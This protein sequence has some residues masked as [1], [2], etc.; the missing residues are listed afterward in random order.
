[1]H[2]VQREAFPFSAGHVPSFVS[3]L[4]LDSVEQSKFFCREKCIQSH[5]TEQA[6]G[7]INGQIDIWIGLEIQIFELN[8]KKNKTLSWG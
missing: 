7:Y 1:M 6:F 8:K 4:F 5:Y 3:D 2:K